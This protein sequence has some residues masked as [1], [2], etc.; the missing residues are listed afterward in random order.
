MDEVLQC[1][2]EDARRNTGRRLQ[3]KTKMA[4]WV[5]GNCMF[6]KGTSIC[7]KKNRHRNK[8]AQLKSYSLQK[9]D[10]VNRPVD[11]VRK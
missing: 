10:L 11:G 9:R 5:A 8:E 1:V 3:P 6:T 7:M 4:V 2:N